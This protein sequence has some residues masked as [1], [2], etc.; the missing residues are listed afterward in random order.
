[1]MRMRPGRQRARELQGLL[2]LRGARRGIPARV[3]LF[4]ASPTT[5]PSDSRRKA[6]LDVRGRARGAAQRR[7]TGTTHHPTAHDTRGAPSDIS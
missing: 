5:A 1:M 7:T 4:G 6:R 2:R 3:G